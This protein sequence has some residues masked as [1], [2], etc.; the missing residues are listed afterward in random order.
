MIREGTRVKWEWGN[1]HAEGSVGERHED[2]VTR[3][4]DGSEVT[5]NGTSDDP[6]LV[7]RQDDGQDVVKLLSEVERA[8]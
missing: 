4:I 2:S 8:D 3:T 7:I 6:V 1:G 5:R